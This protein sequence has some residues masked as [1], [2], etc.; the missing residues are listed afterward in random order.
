[1]RT[2]DPVCAHMYT[3]GR[4][5]IYKR[6]GRINPCTRAHTYAHTRAPVHTYTLAPARLRSGTPAPLPAH[7]YAYT[8]EYKNF[9]LKPC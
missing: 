8:H 5:L 9:L 4:G 2:P 1:M 3:L 6:V 7:T